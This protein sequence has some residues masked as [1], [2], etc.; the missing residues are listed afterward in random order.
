LRRALLAI[1]AVIVV[2]GCGQGNKDFG[3]VSGTVTLDGNSLAGA[4]VEFQPEKGPPSC[5]VTDSR[6]AY[7]LMVGN[8]QRGAKVGRHTIRITTLRPKSNDPHA[9]R[10]S[11]PERIPAKY[12]TRSNLSREVAPGSNRIDLELTSEP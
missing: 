1:L 6:G 2:A 5:G 8:C 10:D 12:N 7:T 11:A 9:K 3:Y 4:R